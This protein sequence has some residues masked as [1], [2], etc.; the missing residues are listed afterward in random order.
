MRQGRAIWNQIIRQFEQSGLSQTEF[1]KQRGIPIGTLH[2]WVKKLRRESSEGAA[3]LIPVRVV[4]SGS[5]AASRG[6]EVAGAVE[7]MVLRFSSGTASEYVS[8][9]VSRLLRC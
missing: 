6:D 3:A 7:V 5:P 2:W 4:R 1:A 8:E 9:V